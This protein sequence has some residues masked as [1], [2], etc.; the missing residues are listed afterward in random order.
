MK[1][2]AVA[3]TS[4][5][6]STN[7]SSMSGQ[8]IFNKISLSDKQGLL[9]NAFVLEERKLANNYNYQQYNAYGQQQQQQQQIDGSFTI[10]FNTCTSLRILDDDV[11]E[12]AS[13]G[14]SFQASKD[15]VIFT[16][17]N[18]YSTRK[19]AIDIPTFV[20]SII[21]MILQ[22]N[23]NYCDVCAEAK[24]QCLY[25][26]YG[27]SGGAAYYQNQNSAYQMSNSDGDGNRFL[28]MLQYENYAEPIDCQTCAAICSDDNNQYQYAYTTEE[29]AEWLE[30]MGECQQVYN[31][32]QAYNTYSGNYYNNEQVYYQNQQQNGGNDG[33]QNQKQD[34]YMNNNLS[35]ASFM[36]NSAGTGM[37]FGLFKDEACTIYDSSAVFTSFLSRGT[38]E[39][40][41]YQKTKQLV[42]YIFKEPISCM[43]TEYINPFE[44]YNV[45]NANQQY[46]QNQSYNRNNGNGQNYG[47]EANDGCQTLIGNGVSTLVSNSCYTLNEN[48]NDNNNVQ[49]YYSDGDTYGEFNYYSND[50][51]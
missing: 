5:V 9:R 3:I 10:N 48:N 6:A 18:D 8:E 29:S 16:A 34:A 17:Y 25:N 31:Q 44:N 30:A 27:N 19:Y 49:Q 26:N 51:W 14:G 24:D 33:N 32:N 13:N 1:V 45:N 41:Y 39:W 11:M 15:Y 35:Y 7:A 40:M 21:G 47:A 38:A 50:G 22:E 12:Y 43:D 37:E 36:C 20:S 42:E 2:G 46:Q 23:E 28:R 4:L